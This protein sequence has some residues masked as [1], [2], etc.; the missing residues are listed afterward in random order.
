MKQVL[1]ILGSLYMLS[2]P[3]GALG[4]VD[5][6]TTDQSTANYIDSLNKNPPSLVDQFRLI[7][8][9]FTPPIPSWPALKR[10]FQ[11]QKYRTEIFLTAMSILERLILGIGLAFFS[12]ATFYVLL[13]RSSMTR[14]LPRLLFRLLL[15]LILITTSTLSYFTLIQSLVPQDNGRADGILQLEKNRE[16]ILDQ[17]SKP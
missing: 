13:F 10:W 4:K 8:K 1:I 14:S 5:P 2:L 11:F 7:A 12:L 15:I 3:A 6:K 17:Q 16:K 9:T